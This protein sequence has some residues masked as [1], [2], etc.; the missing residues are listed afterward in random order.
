MCPCHD[1]LSYIPEGYIPQ[2]AEELRMKNRDLYFEKARTSMIKQLWAMNAF[3]GKEGIQVSEYGNAVRKECRDG[4]MPEEEPMIV[5]YLSDGQ[6]LLE[7]SLMS[8]LIGL[9]GSDIQYGAGRLGGGCESRLL[10]I[11]MST[12]KV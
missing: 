4:G 12:Y 11:G 8:T 6:A 1:P 7:K 3:A 2:E 9:S 10:V 5:A